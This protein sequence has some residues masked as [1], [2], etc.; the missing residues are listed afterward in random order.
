M[1]FFLFFQV[2]AN[3]FTYCLLLND[4]AHVGLVSW[5]RLRPLSFVCGNA[6]LLKLC[7]SPVELL[8]IA[9]KENSLW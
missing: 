6:K 5:I 9:S 8:C 4:E 7:G 1:S 2:D 3:Y